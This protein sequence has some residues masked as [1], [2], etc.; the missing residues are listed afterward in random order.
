MD[1]SSSFTNFSN[2]VSKLIPVKRSTSYYV[3]WAIFIIILV[4]VFFPLS[5][6]QSGLYDDN[7][8]SVAYCQSGGNCGELFT[9]F[10]VIIGLLIGIYLIASYGR[11]YKVIEQI[12]TYGNN[13]NVLPDTTNGFLGAV[14]NG[15]KG[16]I[17]Y[18]SQQHSS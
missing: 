2:N 13:N 1:S 14:D 16:D 18:A 12:S 7:T 9:E 10:I 11:L 4:F 15:L 8:C 6:Y 5:S 3:G 17:S